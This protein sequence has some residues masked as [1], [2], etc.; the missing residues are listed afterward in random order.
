MFTLP[1][2]GFGQATSA[3]SNPGF[4][5]GTT[6]W[7]FFTDGTGSYN[8]IQPGFEGTNAARLTI[9]TTGTNIQLFQSGVTLKANTNYTLSFAAYSSNGRDIAIALQKHTTPF[10]VYGLNNVL[11]DLGTGWNTHTLTFTTTGFTGTVNDGRFRFVVNSY[12][13]AG[14]V[15]YI[16][17]VLL[18]ETPVTGDPPSITSHPQNQ[19]V[20]PGALATFTVTATGTAPL[21][22]QWT[23]DGINIAGATT[24]SYTTPMTSGTD[25]GSVFRCV[26]TNAFGSQTSNPAT[27]TILSLPPSITQQ[28][29]NRTVDFGQAATFS[30][31]ATGTSPLAYQWQKNGIDIS[32]ATSSSYTTPATILADNGSVFRCIVTNS[33]GVD[34]STGAVLTVLYLPPTITQQPQNQSVSLGQTATFTVSASGNSP[35]TYQW[36]KNGIDIN[37]ATSATYT[38]PAT[39]IGDNGAVFKCVVTNPVGVDSTNN[40]ALTVVYSPPTITQQ[41]QSQTVSLGQT[42]TFTLSATGTLPLTYQWKRNG[43]NIGGATNASYTT[44]VTVIGDNGAVFYCIVTNPVGVDSTNN[45][46]LTVVYSPPAVIQQPQSQTVGVGQTATFVVT[47]NGTLPLSY[48]WKKNGV[49]INGATSSSYTT[50]VTV[51][52]DNG[53]VFKCVVTNVAGV[54]SSTGA[55]LTVTYQAPTISQHPQNRSVTT[56][57]TAT[58]TVTAAGSQPLAYQWKKNGTNISGANSSVYTTPAT[59]LADNGSTFQCVVSND[60]GSVT[61]NSASLSVSNPTSITSLLANPGFESG[62]TGWSFYTGGTGSYATVQPG[63][64]GNSAARLTVTTTSDNI[65]LFQAG[66]TLKANT[67]YTLSFAAYSSNGRDLTLSLQKHTTPFTVYGLN[68]VLVD[69]GSAWNTHTV[70]FTTTG[71]TGTVNDGRFRFVVNSLA[72]AGTVYYID[73]VLLYETPL[74]G[75]PP[76]IVGQ[77]QNQVVASGAT[78]TF[79]ISAIGTAPLAYQWQKNGVNIA[80]AT[81]S[82]Y[83][84]PATSVADNGSTFSCA[85]TN[86]FG[87][88]A[89]TSATL[90]VLVLPPSVTQHPQSQTIAVGQTA[91]FGIIATGTL[92]LS[93]Q[94]QKNGVN[95]NGATS[96]S[97]TTPVA[98]LGDNGAVYRCMVTNSAGTD[99][100]NGAVLTVVYLAPTITQHPQNV[101][102]ATGQSAAFNVS[103][104][105]SPTLTYQWQK[106]GINIAGATSASYTTPLNDLSNDGSVYRCIVLNDS[107]S[108]ASNDATLSVTPPMTALSP[109][110]GD[111]YKEFT[112]IMSAGGTSKEWRVTDPGALAAGAQQYKPNSIFSLSINDTVGAIRAEAIIDMW[113]G[114]TGTTNKRFRLNNNSWLTIPE[115]GAANGIPAGKQGQCYQQMLNPVIAVPLSH[116]RQG[117]NTLEGTSGAQTCFS[118][119]WGQWG[120]YGAT[121]RVYYNSNKPHATGTIISPMSGSTIGENPMIA[122]TATGGAGVSRVEFLAYYDGYDTDGDGI[123]Q[124][125]HQNFHRLKTENALMIKNHVGTAIGAPYQVTWNTEFVPDQ[126]PAMVRLIARI[127]DNAGVWFVTDEVKNLTLQ[128]DSVRVKM[129]KPASVAENLNVR[130]T[131]TTAT[132]TYQLP[133]GDNPAQ[134]LGAQMHFRTWNGNNT[135]A[136]SGETHY[137]KLNT[138]TAPVI[139]VGDFYSYDI[140]NVPSSALRTGNNTITVFSNTVQHGIDVHWPGPAIIV[141]YSTVPIV[142]PQISIQPLPQTVTIG[143]TATFTVTATGTQPLSYQW[144][145]NNVN[146]TG[147]TSA[148]Y[149]TPPTVLADNGAVYR[150]VVSN[151]GGSANSAGAGLNIV[152]VPPSVQMQPISQTIQSGRA[153][154][155]S[156]AASGTNPLTYQWQKNGVDISGATSAW[157]ITPVLSLQ[158]SGA[159]Y[160]C[161]VSNS[162]GSLLSNAATISVIATVPP[163]SIVSDDFNSYVLN[164]NLW[165]YI[166]P[167]TPSTLSMLGTGTTDALLSVRLVA[168]SAHDM[169][170]DG[171][172]SPRILQPVNN[173]DFEVESK[174]Q[175]PLVLQNYVGEGLVVEQDPNNYIRFNFIGRATGTQVYAASFVNGTPTTRY[176]TTIPNGTP[177]YM[178]VKREGNSW[179]HRYSYD[180]ATWTVAG[181]FTHSMTMARIGV[182]FS[183]SAGPSVPAFTGTADYFFNVASPIIPEDGSSVPVT[184]LAHPT[185]QTVNSGSPATFTV[186]AAGSPPISY[187]WYRNEQP[188]AGANSS[189]YTL[190]FTQRSDSGS[191][192]SCVVANPGNPPVASNPATLTVLPH[193]SGI[194]SDDFNAFGVLPHWTVYNPLGALIT[195]TGTNTQDALLTIALPAGVEH[196]AWLTNNSAPRLLQPTAN[197]DFELESKFES[198]FTNPFQI[199]GI[200]VQ[201]DPQNFIRFDFNRT[202]SLFAY[203]ASFV[204]GVPTT[205][206]NVGITAGNPMYMRVRRT[207]NQWLQQYSFDGQ[208]WTNAASFSHTLNVTGVGVLAGNAG[209]NPPA[210]TANF[211]YFFLRAEPII[212][213][214][215]GV[216]VDTFPPAIRNISTVPGATNLL[217]E[218][219][220]NEPATSTVQYG[221]TTAY[222]LGSISRSELETS[223]SLDITGL[224]PNTVYNLR[225]VSA[226]ANNN[227]STS[228]N[229]V[230]I[231]ITPTPPVFN[232]WYGKTQTFGQN[233]NPQPYIN[234]LGN[235]QDDNGLRS[236]TYSLN[237]GPEVQL[238][239]GSDLRRLTKKGDFNVDILYSALQ[240]TNTVIIAA[241]D[242]Q[243]TAARETV[244]VNYV[245]GVSWPRS[246]SVN[247]GS[248]GTIQN[249]AQVVDGQWTISNGSLRIV[250][251]GYDRLVAI[252]ERTWSEYEVT[253]SVTIH[254]VD[255]SGF[256]APSHGPGVGFLMRWPGHSDLP[257][258]VAGMQPK[259]GFLPL[260]ALAWYKWGNDYSERLEMLGNNLAVIGQTNKPLALG[261][262]YM[263]KA[264][265]ST[266][267]GV[268]GIYKMKVWQ[269]GTPEPAAWDVQGQQGVGD[270]Q[271]GSLL[272]V[273]HHLDV[274]FGNV[275]VVPLEP[276]STIISDDFFPDTLNTHLWTLVDP[277]ANSSVEISGGGTGDARAAIR[278]PAG[279]K[280]EPWATSNTT[281]RLMQAANDANFEVEAR[282]ESQF[283]A[284]IQM[285]GILVQ[286]DPLNWI[287]FDYSSSG[288]NTKIFAATT[289]NG[290][291]SVKYNVDVATG[292]PPYMRVKRVG[293]QWTLK[294]SYDGVNWTSTPSFN[295]GM[296]VSSIGPFAGNA[297]TNPA[298]TALVDYFFNTEHPINPEDAGGA[299]IPPNIVMHPVNATVMAGDTATF[300]ISVLGTPPLQYQWQRSGVDIAGA[301][302]ATLVVPTTSVLVDSGATFRCVVTNGVGASI[303]S[304]ATLSVL[305][306][307]STIVSDDFHTGVLDTTL[308][309]VVNPRNDATFGF[310]GVGTQNALLSIHVPGDIAHDIW[311]E[312]NFSPQILQAA[313]NTNFEIETK[314]QSGISAV[315]EFHGVIVQEDSRNLIRF[316]FTTHATSNFTRLFVASF[317]NGVPT[318]RIALNIVAKGVAPLYLRVQ[319]QG[320]TWT[321]YWSQNGTTFTNGGSFAH[322][323]VVDSVGV[324]AGNAGAIPPECTSLID[325]FFNTASPVVPEDGIPPAITSHPADRTITE[326]L[327][328][329][330]SVSATGTFLA[331]Q[332][333]KNGLDIP[334]ATSASYTTQPTTMS[335]SGSVY[336]CIVSNQFGSLTSNGARLHVNVAVTLPWWNNAWSF[337]LPIEVNTGGFERFEKPVETTVNFTSALATMGFSSAAFNE[338]SLRVIERD[339]NY[340]VLDTLVSFQFDKDNGYNPSSNAAGTIIFI[341]SGAGTR[342]YD[343]YFDTLGSSHTPAPIPVRVTASDTAD[344]QGQESFKIVTSAGTYYYHKRGAGFASMIDNSGNDWIS[345]QPGG[346]SA[347]EFRGIPNLGDVFHPGYTNSNSFIESPGPIKTRIRSVS[348]SGAWEAVWDIFPRF[349]RM[350]LL[351]KGATYWFLYEGTPGGA[352][353]L[354]RDYVYRSTGTRTPVTT[355]WSQNLPAGKQWAYFGD[356]EI[357]RV[358]YAIQHEDD[359]QPDYFRHMDGNMTIFGFGRKDPCCIR[360]LDVAPQTFTF[361]LAEDSTFSETSKIINSAY[362]PVTITQRDPQIQGSTGIPLLS[363]IVSD[364]FNAQSLNTQ[365]WTYINPRGDA[366]VS[367]TGNALS[368]LVPSGQSHDIWTAGIQAPRVMQ[369][370]NDA[371]FEVEAKFLSSVS[372][373]FQIQGILVQQDA[374]N[375]IRFDFVRHASGTKAFSASFIGGVPTTRVDTIIAGSS[376]IWLRVKRSGN[377]WQMRFSYDGTNWVTTRPFTHNLAVSSIGPFFGN[378]GT[379]PPQF[380]GLIDYFY[381][382]DVPI[383]P[384]GPVMSNYQPENSNVSEPVPEEYFL[385]PNYPNP[386]NPSTTIQFGLP[387]PAQVQLKVYNMLGQLVATLAEQ[388]RSAGYYQV[389]WDGRNQ[390][391]QPVG[392]GVYI[393][394]IVAVNEAGGTFST[395]NKMMLLR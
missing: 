126:A 76:V 156:I 110:P 57:Q 284:Q 220:T 170:T 326:G 197:T 269:D 137:I 251:P 62:T 86:F 164:S 131:R 73:N 2:S 322:A 379:P 223:H 290:S 231:T 29:Q 237:G 264:Q 69:L 314:F 226:D 25:N 391:G 252:G 352:F 67:S 79:S 364:N 372:L 8:T 329:T 114:H 43:V 310:T 175:N 21:S 71:F 316:G 91:T 151:I 370:A 144:Q 171:P 296:I 132:F 286:Q 257:A 54:D 100:S 346:G 388:H 385:K 249:V 287:R 196:N 280:H 177:L 344:Y 227:T 298:Y 211:D 75:D 295:H 84:T 371:N 299:G 241:V 113:G 133:V 221:L 267:P 184:I 228:A 309:R 107:G 10:T 96:A 240:P 77:P 60:S 65:Q 37:G 89:S 23:K 302:S 80:G 179:T 141:R 387:E 337:R 375:F 181:T 212:P 162:G 55:I 297:G 118:F 64:E 153:A 78:A 336:R 350:T 189:S 208:T 323:L 105:G 101:S 256:G 104:T 90:S 63:F 274:S 362:K 340:N 319:R 202:T 393:Y 121:I 159:Q 40:A 180:G 58:F 304:S 88:E 191:T 229:F 13:T 383:V 194:I 7:N 152:G 138:W 293:T 389:K 127:R 307:P 233:G 225:V 192:F 116:L 335:D 312:G 139:G 368:I 342:F 173:T 5:T 235:V 39:V 109:R 38:T 134:A 174:F 374:Q 49:N 70:T 17:N 51:L 94:W 234:I 345:Y 183:N 288:A 283:T 201:Q 26:V 247:W 270:P 163:S 145:K 83:T 3:L 158:D 242:S 182:Y 317:V 35:L 85:V 332:W 369:P 200:L 34:S 243:F 165:T 366:S 209:T 102:V 213:E 167:G 31:M 186:T 147:A 268:G 4:E 266:N 16:D 128:R 199:Q 11:I 324:Y 308:W 356:T 204:N 92:P 338:N 154:A 330:F 230:V 282:F 82:S 136:T 72:T 74:V 281:A 254:S 81:S 122:A 265:V 108:V 278:V 155:F 355:S 178:R 48:Q 161:R 351:R 276:V 111:I 195:T 14:T 203:A 125:Y 20:E 218:W 343:V 124:D 291:S 12:A 97:Y 303:S 45:A 381:N 123:F 44:P 395:L 334:G 318:T 166:N 376:P 273:A 193:P 187:Q 258:T 357:P 47:A 341:V 68:N 42:A 275:S 236:L 188:I 339:S 224:Q 95:I 394:R 142:A 263:F 300:S 348:T 279:S 271:T 386:F 198:N 384:T 1:S 210:F 117:T 361:G 115:L 36:K 219:A 41:P 285:H 6:G 327:R 378:E 354:D 157:Y 301:N 248:A 172:M 143:Q 259:T 33:V 206:Y 217:V 272:L 119:S 30:V 245:G 261:V 246:Y 321:T 98:V 130:A 238:S 207:G 32:G 377:Q 205:R 176:Q 66:V 169:W 289:I 294:Y 103:A 353:H 320:N 360:Y 112:V 328:A 333:Q 222:E 367:M 53:S 216:A 149:T 359:A 106:N 382:V 311:T 244:T 140:V 18:Y 15:Y 22:Y 168:G 315:H 27:L 365:L 46:T 50:P 99:L 349:A 305:Y 129:Y 56:G 250:Q 148:F 253:T 28:P 215:G 160:T 19:S 313:N 185:N 61:S 135:G 87:S 255:S 380:T 120:W 277:L 146:I 292:T 232:V 373:S 190:P 262:R 363:T 150:C 52:A 331:Y 392:S 306:P 214:D 59:V 9:T 358:L 390:D 347:G 93:Y 260:G 239:I 325:Y 24:S